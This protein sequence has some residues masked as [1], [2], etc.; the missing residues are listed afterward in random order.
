MPQDEKHVAAAN[1]LTVALFTK[2]AREQSLIDTV[3]Q[4]ILFNHLPDETPAA[5][6]KQIATIMMLNA[7]ASKGIPL[8]LTTITEMTGMTRKAAQEVIDPLIKRGLLTEIWGRT[9]LGR[10]K[11]K[12]FHLTTKP[13][14]NR[15]SGSE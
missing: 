3:L 15:N 11:A 2:C 1:K 9:S 7:L 5:R 14:F 6:L 8:S 10:G 4:E 12:M 13:S